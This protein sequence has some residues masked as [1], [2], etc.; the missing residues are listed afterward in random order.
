MFTWPYSLL[1][2]IIYALRVNAGKE[3]AARKPERFGKATQVCPEGNLLYCHGA[4]VG[5]AVSLFPL[6]DH[7]L[8]EGHFRILVTTYTKTSAQ[9][10]AQRYGDRLIHQFIPYDH[11]AYV[12]KFLDYWKPERVIW[13]E[14]ELWPAML[15]AI[16]KRHIPAA[17]INARLSPRSLARWQRIKKYAQ[18]MLSTFSIILTQTKADADNFKSLGLKNIHALGNIKYAAAPLPY[19]DAKLAALQVIINTRPAWVYASTHKGEEEI[20]VETH[21]TLKATFPNLLTIVVPRHPERREA[22]ADAFRSETLNIL[23][24]GQEKTLPNAD[25]DIYVADTLGDLGLFYKLAP[26]AMIGRTLSDDG[27]GGHNPLEAAQLDCAIL[28]GPH[29]QN[30]QAIFDELHA[31]HACIAVENKDALIAT[32]SDLLTHAE[33]RLKLQEKAKAFIDAKKKILVD[34]IWALDHT[35]NLGRE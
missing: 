2:H 20:A 32:I 27:G 28:H 17:L 4:S 8:A 18:K 31:A 15:S 22:I 9:M 12:S 19:D 35:F 33:K 34:L 23:F 5:E 6:L 29:V 14:S 3:I 11:P 21:K 1:W 10:V 16:K 7:Y 26:I 13:T 24:R 30:L 25:T